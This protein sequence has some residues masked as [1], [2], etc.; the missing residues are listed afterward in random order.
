M[1]EKEKESSQ[2]KES[3]GPSVLLGLVGAV[4]V[5]LLLAGGIWGISKIVSKVRENGDDTQEERVAESEDEDSTEDEKDQEKE[6][7]TEDTDDEEDTTDDSEQDSEETEPD[8]DADSEDESDDEDTTDDTTAK[9]DS[10]ERKEEKSSSD[11]GEVMAES[12]VRAWEANDYKPGDIK[13][14]TY[15]VVWGDTLWEIAE[16]R[17]G[18]GFD[19]MKIKDANSDGVSR[20]PNGKWALILPGQVLSLPK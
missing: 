3:L 11:K 10:E 16:G 15:T 14:D 2:K 6:E 13:G 4:V 19:W 20:L 18:S 5:L 12:G 17:Y 8:S 7:D 1:A 9:P